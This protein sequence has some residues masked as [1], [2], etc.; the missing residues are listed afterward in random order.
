MNLFFL[1]IAKEH[2]IFAAASLPPKYAHISM[3]FLSMNRSLE[4]LLSRTV[5]LSHGNVSQNVINSSE[6]VTEFTLPTEKATQ[7]LTG[8][9][10]NISITMEELNKE[11]QRTRNRR[12][13]I[14]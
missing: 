10:I 9:P 7:S 14:L 1:R 8:I 11:L 5:L 13:I 3:Q 2:T 12:T 4:R 6:L